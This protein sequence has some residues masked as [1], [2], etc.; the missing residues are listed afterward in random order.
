MS[1]PLSSELLL[2]AKHE[3]DLEFCAE[4]RL[5]ER[6]ASTPLVLEPEVGSGHE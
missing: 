5:T 1:T 2:R 4:S 6:S 3:A